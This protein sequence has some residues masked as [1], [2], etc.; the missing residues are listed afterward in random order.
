MT[1]PRTL[2]AAIPA[3]AALVV[4]CGGS[5]PPRHRAGAEPAVAPAPARTP[6]GHVVRV[7]TGAE[8]IVVDAPAGLVAL[9][10]RMPTRIA[11][12]SARSGRLIRHLRIDGPARDL[13]LNGTSTLHVPEAPINRLLE[14]P[15]S[16]GRH[17]PPRRSIVTASLPHDATA[18]DGR[19]FVADEFGHA[20]SVLAGEREIR[21]ITGFTQP[22]GITAVGKDVALADV[23]AD[24]VTLIDGRSLRVLGHVAIGTGISHDVTGPAGRLYVADTRG[25]ALFTLATRPRL[26]LLSRLGL[27]GT[28]YGLASDPLRRRLW[29]TETATNTVAELDT[30]RPRPRV[31]TT[32]PTVRQPNTVAVDISSGRV[33]IAGASAGVVQFFDPAHM[34]SLR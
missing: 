1:T 9:A 22:G 6:V 16:A 21:Q 34:R 33:F 8:G 12:L 15:L 32:F 20:V 11:L 17:V 26:R 3:L 18:I 24:V 29:V 31:I 13:Q 4:G 28:P 19:I 10:V 5:Q 30:S 14:L 27:P 25:G 2:S 23:G 7:G